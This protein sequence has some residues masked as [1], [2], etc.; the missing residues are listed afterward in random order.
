[1][2]S[3]WASVFEM[4]VAASSVNVPRRVSVSAGSS[5][6]VEETTIAPQRSPAT[7]IGIPTLERMPARRTASAIVPSRPE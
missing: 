1:V 6:V 2:A 4:A 5:M 7:T 3:A